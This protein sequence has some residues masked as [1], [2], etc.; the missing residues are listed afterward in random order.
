MKDHKKINAHSLIVEARTQ[1]QIQ[2]HKSSFISLPYLQRVLE[3]SYIILEFSG[4]LIELLDK[5][6][7][8]SVA[9]G[10]NVDA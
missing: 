5:S 6:R 3:L 9:N 2:A 1:T 7:R 8:M 10:S 4:G